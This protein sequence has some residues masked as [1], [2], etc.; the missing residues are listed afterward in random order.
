MW[1]K[2]FPK[3]ILSSPKPINKGQHLSPKTEFK[4][5]IAPSN[6]LPVGSL[7]VRVQ[8][9]DTP[10]Y[11]RKIGESNTWIPNAVFIWI[12]NGGNI[13]KGFILHHRDKDTLN[14][15]IENL[16]LV[17]RGKHRNI[18]HEDLTKGKIGLKL[19]TKTVWCPKCQKTIY[20]KKAGTFC[21]EC[22]KEN[23][24]YAH[25]TYKQRIRDRNRSERE[26]PNS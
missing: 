11:W 5:G 10:R 2:P 7:T 4:K 15:S 8:K 26:S 18:H 25:R 17:T 23:R 3:G 12:E 14:D 19:K 13:P 21:E 1:G 16:S 20:A 22:K 6:K 9:D 24:R